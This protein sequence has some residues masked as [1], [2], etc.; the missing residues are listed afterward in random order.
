MDIYIS[1]Y[2]WSKLYS[3]LRAVNK[4]AFQIIFNKGDCSYIV[5]ISV[6]VKTQ[7]Y[8]HFLQWENSYSKQEWSWLYSS[9]IV[10]L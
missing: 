9:I 2:H 5:D 8:L 3:A 6:I 10:K 4:G 1:I 7:S